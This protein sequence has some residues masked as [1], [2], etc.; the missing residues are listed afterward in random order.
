M[1]PICQIVCNSVAPRADRRALGVP[2]LLRP[3]RRGGIR[4]IWTTR[5][6]D[7]P[8]RLRIP[9]RRA[10]LAKSS[11]WSRFRQFLGAATARES[12][13]RDVDIAAG[14]VAA[15][16]SK[17]RILGTFSPHKTNYL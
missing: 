11:P 9:A 7:L 5:Q 10:Q 4:R 14:V 16:E 1:G 12:A 2:F 8:A 6:K 15:A 3:P 17:S 13:E